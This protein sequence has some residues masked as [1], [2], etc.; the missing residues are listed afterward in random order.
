MNRLYS[1][2]KTYYNIII[3]HC[4]CVS[5]RIYLQQ[6]LNNSVGP[7]IV[8]DFIKFN[9]AW[10]T[11]Q[12]KANNWGPLTSNLLLIGMPG[13]KF[14]IK[15]AYPGNMFTLIKQSHSAYVTHRLYKTC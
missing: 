2:L 15:M 12:Q 4:N 7:E 11:S 9:W 8:Q 1:C 13:S 14:K 6:A 10:V 3:P 5:F